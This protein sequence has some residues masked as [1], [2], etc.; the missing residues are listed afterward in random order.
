M[1]AAAHPEVHTLQ[2]L[3]EHLD[4]VVGHSGPRGGFYA[5]DRRGLLQAPT[6]A[7]WAMHHGLKVDSLGSSKKES[8]QK[9]YRRVLEAQL[10]EV[11]GESNWDVPEG[12]TPHAA[13]FLGYDMQKEGTDIKVQDFNRVWNSR[14]N[15]PKDLPETVALLLRLKLN[16]PVRTSWASKKKRTG[17][18]TGGA[19]PTFV[20]W[21]AAAKVSSHINRLSSTSKDSIRRLF[22]KVIEAELTALFWPTQGETV[23]TRRTSLAASRNAIGS[24]THGSFVGGAY[25]SRQRHRGADP[26]NNE[27]IK[28]TRGRF[29]DFGEAE[30]LDFVQRFPEVK[31]SD[32]I[33]IGNSVWDNKTATGNQLTNFTKYL[34]RLA[35]YSII[36]QMRPSMTSVQVHDTIFHDVNSLFNVVKAATQAKTKSTIQPLDFI[37]KLPSMPGILTTDKVGLK[38][39]LQDI[40][41]RFPEFMSQDAFLDELATRVQFGGTRR[42]AEPLRN[43]V[44]RIAREEGAA[45]VER[46]HGASGPPDNRFALDTNRVPAPTALDGL[47]NVQFGLPSTNQMVRTKLRKGTE[48]FRPTGAGFFGAPPHGGMGPLRQEV[49][50]NTRDMIRQIANELI[51]TRS[52]AQTR[53]GEARRQ[54]RYTDRRASLGLHNRPGN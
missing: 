44:D 22:E 54:A 21:A 27:L 41:H 43:I 39:I 23:R 24:A 48:G 31:V 49:D 26:N 29:V 17:R 2:D 38:T 25:R 34:R 18:R 1:P 46:K 10:T 30:A 36:K 35:A 3:F 7:Q 37:A 4:Q 32:A 5:A 14:D 52:F 47:Q 53:H 33:H 6:F 40:D 28:W 42:Q 9:A 8:W 19:P 12:V 50:R 51:A 13:G 45:F 15:K 16:Q 11:F 20:Q